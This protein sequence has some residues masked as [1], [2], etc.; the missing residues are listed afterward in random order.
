MK[1]INFILKVA[2]FEQLHN[3]YGV[4]LFIGDNES[5]RFLDE[6]VLLSFKPIQIESTIPWKDFYNAI[7]EKSFIKNDKDERLYNIKNTLEKYFQSKYPESKI[8]KIAEIS[9]STNDVELRNIL[10]GNIIKEDVFSLLSSSQINFKI[11]TEVVE[12]DRLD[13]GESN[14]LDSENKD[15]SLSDVYVPDEGCIVLEANPIIDP[16]KGKHAIEFESGEKVYI[17]IIDE[18]V[19]GKHLAESITKNE[20]YQSVELISPIIDSREMTVYNNMS[21]SDIVEFYTYL[22]EEILAHFSVQP[23][24]LLM[25]KPITEKGLEEMQNND[26]NME[27]IDEKTINPVYYV[28]S[29]LIFVIFISAIIYILR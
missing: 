2:F 26:S 5:K 7:E 23:D 19:I 1:K 22:D 25:F 9:A 20:D 12:S 28:I 11:D 8:K 15:E 4:M 3:F 6:K 16:V 17:K 18:T 29:V 10:L 21:A 27:I 13:S 24:T 14:G